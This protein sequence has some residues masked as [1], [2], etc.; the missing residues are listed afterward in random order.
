M[1]QDMQC[2]YKS[3]TEVGS[4]NHFCSGKTISITYFDCVFVALVTQHA[5][6]MLHIVICDLSCSTISF[7][8]IA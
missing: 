4:C 6:S 5:M 2:T 3:N 8:I 7:H 1:Q